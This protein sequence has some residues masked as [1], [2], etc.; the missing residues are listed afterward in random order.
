M[1]VFI[2]GV[3]LGVGRELACELVQAGHN[4]FGV[5]RR[6]ELLEELSRELGSER[7]EATVCDIRNTEDI[8]RVSELMTSRRFVPDV[9]VLNAGITENDVRPVF[10]QAVVRRVIETNLLGALAWAEAFLPAMIEQREGQFVAISSIFAFRPDE[11]NIS[12]AASKS[13]LAMAFRGLRLA[14]RETGVRFK[15][16]YFGPLLTGLSPKFTQPRRFFTASAT[17]AARAL[18]RAIGSGRNDF[19]FPFVATTLVRLTRWLP[20]AWFAAFSKPFRR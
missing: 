13:A 12:Y 1:K 14:Y 4:V 6:R 20:D 18:I 10:Q 9:V 8:K 11:T 19:Y 7:F 5:A 17:A 16:M 15:I 3:S 2:T